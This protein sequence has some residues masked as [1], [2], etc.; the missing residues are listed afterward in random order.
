MPSTKGLTNSDLIGGVE[1]SK[2]NDGRFRPNRAK[3]MRGGEFML[4]QN[5]LW[6]LA[7]ARF[8]WDGLPETVN[9]RYLERVLHRHGLA[10]FFEDPRLHAFFAL[11]AAGTGDVDVYGDPKTFRVTGN[12]YI[13]R[14]ISSKDCVPIW[15]NRNR[16]NDQWV[17]NYYAAALAEAAETVR[18][19]ALNSRSPM[20]LA[21]SQEQRLAGENFYRQVAEGQPVIFTVKDD[22]GRG[23]AESVQA[24]DNRQSPN[25]ISD[26]IRVKKEIWDDAMLALGIQCAPPDKKERL[27]DDEVEAIQ[28]QT[29]AFRGVA[30]GARQE[31]ADAINERYGL[32]VSVHWRHSREQVRGI[33]D[34]GEG[35]D[36]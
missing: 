20:I 7:E 35:F 19:N 34:L 23:V 30:I 25:A 16:V 18:V 17:V 26:A 11:H 5:M 12:R 3:A 24:L 14:E 1:P 10:V 4:Y 28:G 6:G 21:L 22:M 36:G 33:N 31:A 2:M 13:N 32:N 9:E 8:V 29:A 27:V 15:T